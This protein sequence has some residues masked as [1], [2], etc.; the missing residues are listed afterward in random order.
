MFY[1]LSSLFYWKTV[2]DRNIFP[3]VDQPVGG[4][5]KEKSPFKEQSFCLFLYLCQ[6]HLVMI[7]KTIQL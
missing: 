6:I 1:A 3:Y 2:T 4:C 5:G 7:R